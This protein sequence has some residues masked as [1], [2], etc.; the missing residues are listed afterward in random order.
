M[1][2]SVSW[3]TLIGKKVCAFRGFKEGQSKYAKLGY[4][5]FDDQETILELNEQDTHSYHDC[6]HS[7]RELR[8][9][10]DSRFW[11]FLFDEE[12]DFRAVAAKDLGH[13]PF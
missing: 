13:D 2:V 10:K 3:S 4:V 8:L 1:K 12:G 9:Y 5:L 7:A 11:T 6:N